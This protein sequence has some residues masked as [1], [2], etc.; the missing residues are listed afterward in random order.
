VLVAGSARA[1]DFT[2]DVRFPTRVG[3]VYSG[4][5]RGPAFSFS[6]AIEADVA[7]VA[8]RVA[9]TVFVDADSTS[10]LDLPD[11]DPR[12]GFGNVGAGVGIFYVSRGSVAFGIESAPSL[13]FDSQDVVGVGFSTRATLFPFY[14]SFSEALDTRHDTFSAW[15]RS[16]I[17]LWVLARV[18]FTADGNGGSLGFG[19]SFDLARMLFMPYAQGVQKLFH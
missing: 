5:T 19:V 8:P 6:S 15:V 9:L 13:A 3:F 1:E 18:D 17:S 16:G 12:A 11:Q 4:V 14:V 2:L 10:R 7:R